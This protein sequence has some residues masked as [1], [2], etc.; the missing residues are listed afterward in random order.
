MSN[1]ATTET[2][3]LTTGLDGVMQVSGTR[4]TLDSIIAAF[5]EG[6]TAEE[7]AQQYPSVPLTD[8]YH[9]LGYYLRHAHELEGYLGERLR[10]AQEV[11]DENESRWNPEG[12][13]QRLM[14]RRPNQT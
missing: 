10:R 4:V 13:R 3:P 2:I 9:L 14:S 12:I 7:I 6:A 11:R 8:V 5:R 1:N